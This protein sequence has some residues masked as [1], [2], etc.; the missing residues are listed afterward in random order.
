MTIAATPANL[1]RATCSLLLVGL[2]VSAMVPEPPTTETLTVSE[3][4]AA[5]AMGVV[6][7]WA[8]PP[9]DPPAP[10]AIDRRPD[11][12]AW[13]V[14]S[15][16]SLRQLAFAWSLPVSRLTELNPEVAPHDP[17]PAGTAVAVYRAEDA[18]PDRSIGPPNAGRLRGGVPMP[19]G[20]PWQ[21]RKDRSRVWGTADTVDTLVDTFTAYG[22]RFPDAHPVHLGDLSAR[23]GGRIGP[24][25]SHQSGR[26]V[27]IR[28]VSTALR[29]DG[30]PRLRTTEETF[31][32]AANWFVVKRLLASG[33]VQSIYMSAKVQRWLRE[34]AIANVGADAARTY[35][36]SISHE[37]GH[38]HHMHVRFR[39]PDGHDACRE[40]TK[41]RPTPPSA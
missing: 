23:R 24:H 29:D 4:E 13:H 41:V 18:R 12:V 36:E 38:R 5:S 6:I 37:H 21:L 9:V 7:P 10:V 22:E 8:S 25:R 40:R 30:T 35:F 33:E 20:E 28:F 2:S 34:Q 1:A 27:D 32:A 17:L 39:C 3:P 15:S 14:P 26:D 11:V 19:E 16:M 31:D